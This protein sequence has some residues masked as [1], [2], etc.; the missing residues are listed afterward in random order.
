[1]EKLWTTTEAAKF[2]GVD[3]AGVQQLVKDGKLTGYKLGGQ[4]VRFQ[5]E[6]VRALKSQGLAQSRPAA[7]AG[8]VPKARWRQKLQDVW[9][10]YDFYLLSFALLAVI[11]VYLIAS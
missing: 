7:V 3:E 6:Q 2:L 10:F 5:P 1:M 9:Y 4:F 11:V 8:A